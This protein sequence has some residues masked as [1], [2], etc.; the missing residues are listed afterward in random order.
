MCGESPVNGCDPFY[1]FLLVQSGPWICTEEETITTGFVE[2]TE[3][4]IHSRK[5]GNLHVSTPATETHADQDRINQEDRRAT[6]DGNSIECRV[7]VRLCP[8]IYVNRD[9][10]INHVPHLTWRKDVA[11]SDTE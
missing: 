8:F 5:R 10:R 2:S 6:V 1:D 3:W 9:Q 4:P 11:T 7:A